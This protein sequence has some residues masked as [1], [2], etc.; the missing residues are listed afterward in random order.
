MGLSSLFK[1]KEEEKKEEVVTEKTSTI[2]MPSAAKTTGATS[3]SAAGRKLADAE[4][5]VEEKV[6]EV[7]PRVKKNLEELQ[8]GLEAKGKQV[9]LS[10]EELEALARQVIRGDFGNGAERKEKLEAAGYN[11]DEVQG[12]VNEI[13][14]IK[15]A[16]KK[17]EAPAV[18]GEKKDLNTI[19]REVI[20]GNWGNGAE[21]KKRLEE[22]G[23]NYA[24]VQGKVNEI[25]AK[26]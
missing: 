14:G 25:L 12:K 21:R 15:V 11:Y 19:A 4:A 23:Y 6:E 2:N 13:L 7:K 26:K 22:A 10:A 16:E 1:K 17:E 5:K 18:E 3:T 9:S 24:E 20:R 8:A